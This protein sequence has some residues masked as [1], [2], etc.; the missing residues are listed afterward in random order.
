MAPVVR[1]LK[2]LGDADIRA[3]TVY[4]ASFGKTAMSRPDQDALASRLE[5]QTGARTLS[6]FPIGQ[7]IYEGA[8]AVCHQVGG[9]PLF[10]SRPSLSLNSNL[11]SAFP[12]NLIQVILNGVASPVSSDLGFMPAFK[13]SFSDDQLAELVPHLRMQFAPEKPAWSGVPEAIKR[14]RQGLLR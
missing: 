3:I 9:P 7:R 6:A 10:G 4:L 1:N 2:A 5:T 8:C 11:H 12:D 13:D 14:I